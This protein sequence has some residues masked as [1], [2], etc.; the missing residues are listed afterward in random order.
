MLLLCVLVVCGDFV[1]VVAGGDVDVVEVAVIGN[2]NV[3]S[4]GTVDSVQHRVDVNTMEH[5]DATELNLNEVGLVT[6]S[7][8]APVALDEYRQVPGNGSLVIIDRISNITIAAGM[9][10]EL[11]EG[12]VAKSIADMSY[13][14]RLAGFKEEVFSLVDKYLVVN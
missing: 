11:A 13:E 10:R 3:K 7:L 8:N 6:I 14:E 12:G 5:L 2:V 4:Y 1:D 9:V